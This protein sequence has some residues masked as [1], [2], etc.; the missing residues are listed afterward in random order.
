MSGTVRLGVVGLG[1]VAQL[2]YL[3][4][5]VRR[6]DEFL[7]SAVCDA[8]PSAR[9]AFGK[10]LSVPPDRRHATLDSLLDAGEIDALLLLTSGSHGSGARAVA[11]AGLPVLVEK[12]L[13]YTLAEADAL[14]GAPTVQLGYMKRFD[15]AVQEAARLL[16]GAAQ[17][18]SVEVVVLHPSPE[19]QVAQL[20]PLLH[21]GDVPEQT[22]AGWTHE[23]RQL[24]REAL[25]DAVETYGEFY[26]DVLLGS[27]V[28]DLALLRGFVGDPVR[29]D[30]ADIWP[31]GEFPASVEISAE[32]PG[33]ARLSIRWHYMADY[34]AYREHF[35][36]HTL[37]GTIQLTFPSP[38]VLHA[39]TLLEA[40]SRHA[41]GERRTVYRSYGEA[42]ERQLLDFHRLVI[43]G[44]E[45]TIGV[46]EGRA[47]I[48]TC[49]RIVA[50][51]AERD[52]V[53]I[54]GEAATI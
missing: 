7:V 24:G 33:E 29:I 10:R 37:E 28:H 38:Y 46:A 49:Q 5:L 43:D 52:G 14:V 8:S 50:A 51:L 25:G 35:R 2:V 20:P 22:V 3:P 27:F 54:G 15:P 44:G 16:T 41:G 11:D 32:L 4:L 34:P 36:L 13:A 17:L 23:T 12:P 31:R 1:V 6:P 48:V 47:D 19:R 26:T 42:F 21:P 39:P 9:E 53:T 18:R 45:P 40:S 30:L